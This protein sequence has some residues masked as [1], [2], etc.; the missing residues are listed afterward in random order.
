MATSELS[1][2]PDEMLGGNLAMDQHRI[3]GESGNTSCCFATWKPG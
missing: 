3:Q 2:K 1:W